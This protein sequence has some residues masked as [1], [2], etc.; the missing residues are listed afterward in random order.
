M[1][2]INVFE[3]QSNLMES[4]NFNFNIFKN[5]IKMNDNILNKIIV[6]I[7]IVKYIS[8]LKK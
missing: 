1:W 8:C 7:C 3:Q 4:R 2:T 6:E 5:A